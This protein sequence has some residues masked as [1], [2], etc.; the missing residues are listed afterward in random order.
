MRLL[1]DT[2]IYL[3]CL[4]DDKRLSQM[5]R[6][7]INS[8]NEVYVSSVSIWEAAIKMKLGKLTVDIEELITAIKG[9]GFL[10]LPLTPDHAAAV[11]ELPDL[12]R[13]PF[14]R[15]LVAQA[16]TEPLRFLTADKTLES[17]SD[18]ILCV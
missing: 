7:Q 4:N 16:I 11:C 14:D 9:S 10:G 1:L 13:D 15:M 5:A 12:H 17:Y 3:W 8:A 18:L 2:H 6:S